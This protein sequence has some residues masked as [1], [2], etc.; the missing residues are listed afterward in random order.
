[1]ITPV[2]RG[3]VPWRVGDAVTLYLATVMG[4]ALIA[5]A[6]YGAAGTAK[7]S[8]QLAWVNVGAVGVAVLGTGNV[9]WLLAGRRAIGARRARLLRIDSVASTIALSRSA[10]VAP[11]PDG[12]LVASVAM[13]RFHRATCLL[14][15]GKDMKGATRKAHERAG[16]RP[17]GV[18]RP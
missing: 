10:D 9:L 1:V 16:R 8:T 4:F 11:L 12:E 17:C 2:R 14:A 13:T 15:S 6:W 18:C 3:I 7:L 5:L